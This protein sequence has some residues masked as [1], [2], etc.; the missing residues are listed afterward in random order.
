MANEKEERKAVHCSRLAFSHTA[1]KWRPSCRL[2]R[3]GSQHPVFLLV[4]AFLPFS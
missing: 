1:A 2:F 4:T 3:L